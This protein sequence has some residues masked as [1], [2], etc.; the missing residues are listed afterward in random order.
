MRASY[1][2]LNF[3]TYYID[4]AVVIHSTHTTIHPGHMSEL[5]ILLHIIFDQY[6][7]TLHDSSTLYDSAAGADGG[8]LAGPCTI[9]NEMDNC[10]QAPQ[11]H[12]I[13]GVSK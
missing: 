12:E 13:I 2:L 11:F 4:D 7:Q 10:C 6:L 5:H 3:L 8:R 1:L 9:W